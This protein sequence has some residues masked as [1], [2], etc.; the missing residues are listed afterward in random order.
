MA[1]NLQALH[2]PTGVILVE[3]KA[4]SVLVA[5]EP[6][7]EVCENQIHCLWPENLVPAVGTVVQDHV[8]ELCDVADGG[9]ETSMTSYPTR[10]PMHSRH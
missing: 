1:C 4:K 9:E 5:T 3:L 6:G 7:V 8:A 2:R 10:K